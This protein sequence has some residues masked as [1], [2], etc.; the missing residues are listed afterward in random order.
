MRHRA[1][2]M[3]TVDDE[4]K[5][6]NLRKSLAD[7]AVESWR[8]GKVFERMLVKMEL[9]EQKRYKSQ[10]RWFL[11]KT[12][13]SLEQ[14]GLKMVNVEGLPFDAG[15]AVTAL[16]VDE[17]DADDVLIVD[18]MLEPIIMGESGLF[19]TGTVVLRKPGG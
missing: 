18:Q 13:E 7:M 12:E 16:N 4:R 15:M 3:R 1:A 14:A 10:F 5:L 11:R 9:S 8:L 17:F 2:K 6:E 19:R